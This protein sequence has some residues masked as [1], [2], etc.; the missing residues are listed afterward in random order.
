MTS[1]R[2]PGTRPA[3]PSCG[4]L[5]SNRKQ[6]LR[7]RPVCKQ[8]DPSDS[9]KWLAPRSLST[10]MPWDRMRA[11][12]AIHSWPS[13]SRAAPLTSVE[14]TRLRAWKPGGPPRPGHRAV[15]RSLWTNGRRSPVRRGL[16][17]AVN[18]AD[19]NGSRAPSTTGLINSKNGQSTLHQ[20]CR[21]AI[22]PQLGYVVGNVHYCVGQL[23]YVYVFGR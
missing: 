14:R 9:W 10:E 3:W 22:V 1:S 21:C 4:F 5:G 11:F 19:E 18:L 6:N 13:L 8:F 17:R 7:A 15:G 20:L 12:F 2:V 16:I 23:I